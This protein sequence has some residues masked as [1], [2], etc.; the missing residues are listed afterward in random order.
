[1]VKW[2]FIITWGLEYV[3][4]YRRESRGSSNF[5]REEKEK[6]ERERQWCWDY[7]GSIFDWAIE[8]QN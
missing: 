7:F 2:N 5:Y 4:I 8:R 1:M 3:A 6:R